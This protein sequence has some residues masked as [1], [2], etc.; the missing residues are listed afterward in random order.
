MEMIG[1]LAKQ[2]L[3][4]AIASISAQCDYRDCIFIIGHMRC[5]STALSNV[6]CSRPEVSGYGEAH[7]AYGDRSALGILALNQFRRGAWR[8]GATRLFDKI[9][10]SRYDTQADPAFFSSRAIFVFR[11]PQ[12]SILS[13]RTMFDAIGSD[14]YPDDR[15]AASYYRERMTDLMALWDRFPADRRIGVTHERLTANPDRELTRLSHF[16]GFARPLENRYSSKKASQRRG[17]GDPLVSHKLDSIVASTDSLSVKEGKR[18]LEL[19]DDEI[20]ELQKIYDQFLG[21]IQS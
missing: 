1:R 21:L 2:M 3:G 19:S 4:G 16:L 18:K 9:L 12:P 6:L 7:V 5:G 10:H 20:G 15:A 14:E 17:A 11:A 13:I 8:A